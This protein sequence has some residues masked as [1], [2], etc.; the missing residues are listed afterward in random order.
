MNLNKLR[1]LRNCVTPAWVTR[2]SWSPGKCPGVFYPVL[3]LVMGMSS[4]AYSQQIVDEWSTSHGALNAVPDDPA[5]TL[6]DESVATEVVNGAGIITAVTDSDGLGER[7]VRVEFISGGSGGQTTSS[8]G[9]GNL[10]HGEVDSRGNTFI[11]WDGED[12]SAA[13]ATF[14]GSNNVSGGGLDTTGLRGTGSSGLNLEQACPGAQDSFALIAGDSDNSLDYDVVIDIFT[15][16]DSWSSLS[17][18]EID[19]GL[20]S[21]LTF[22]F[23]DFVAQGSDAN[24]ADFT[25]VGA[26]RM[27]ITPA[28]Q[29]V[30]LKV[31]TPFF[32]CGIDLGDAAAELEVTIPDVDTFTDFVDSR[33]SPANGPAGNSGVIENA[34]HAI[35]GPRLGPSVDAESQTAPP[36]VA[37]V[38][39]AAQASRDDNTGINDNDG[40]TFPS[41]LDLNAGDAFPV[42]ISV[43]N[44]LDSDGALLCGWIDFTDTDQLSDFGF[45]NDDNAVVQSDGFRGERL[46]TEVNTTNCAGTEPD[47]TCTLDFVIPGNWNGDNGDPGGTDDAF[48]SRFRVTTDWA[49]EAE[50]T[51]GGFASDGEVE[52][53]LISSST[54]PVSIHSFESKYDSEG[55]VLEWGTVSETRNVG[56]F[57]WGDLGNGL[58][59]LTPEMIPAKAVD[60]VRPHRYQVTVPGVFEGQVGDL[61][62]TAVDYDGDEEVYGLFQAGQAYGKKF[63]PAPVA[64][65]RIGANVRAR[66]SEHAAAAARGLKD[67]KRQGSKLVAYARDAG[68]EDSVAAVDVRT[69]AVGLHEVSWSDLADA[70]LDLAGVDSAEIAVTLKGQPV[71]RDITF[72]VASQRGQARHSASLGASVDQSRGPTTFGPGDVIRF[73]TVEP[74]LPDALYLDNYSY[75]ISVNPELAHSAG[76]ETTKPKSGPATHLE[77]IE[78]DIDNQY[79]FANPLEDPWFAARLRA[80]TNNVYETQFMVDDALRIDQPGTLE[81]VAGGFT[82]FPESP[83]HQLQVELN[84]EV[85]ADVRF[86]GLVEKRIVADVPAGL[87]RPG[88]N[89]VQVI[90]PG[91]TDAAF[92]VSIVDKVTLR[93]PRALVARQDRFLARN[94]APEGGL[95]VSGFLTTDTVAYA[96]D[97]RDLTRLA[98]EQFSRGT[99]RVPTLDSTNAD[100]WIS[101]AG[102][103]HA[104]QD[105][106]PVL[107][108][109]LLAGV[110]G[111]FVIIAHRAFL[112]LSPDEPHPL[113]DYLAA[114]QDEGWTP[115]VFDVQ[116]IQRQFGYGMTLPEAVTNFLR[117]ASAR[118]AFDHVLLVG[119]DSYDYSDN[120][121]LGSIS[122]I[123]TRY[124][125][126]RAIPHTPSDNLLGDI[127]G[128]GVSDKALGRWPVRSMGDLSAIVD[129]TLD[130]SGDPA[131][132]A[133]AAWV[134]DSQDPNQP[135]F[136]AQVQRMVDPLLNAGWMEN[137]IQQILLDEVEPPPGTSV[138]DAA[139][140]TYFDRLESSRSLS[141]FVGHGAP[142]MWT[143]QGLLTP[144]DLADLYN[145]GAPTLIGTL[146]CYTSYFV[147]PFNDTVA[148]RWMNG[149][150]EDA[151]GNRIDGV[152]NGAVAIHGAAT[153]SNYDQNGWFAREVLNKQ[154]AGQ[155][156]GQAILK[157]RHESAPTSDQVINWNLLGDPTLTLD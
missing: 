38:N 17:K 90:A 136:A 41:L 154:L 20:T 146:T 82:D 27:R 51:L 4:L 128:D 65:N 73:W 153:L 91:G 135:S 72:N 149:Y 84:G 66:L 152:P 106:S 111:D 68:R 75:R 57:V 31:L 76:I 125:P 148:H 103:V 88:A 96:W 56:F 36:N 145:E 89:T 127:D 47:L 2:K 79:H 100:Y 7:D 42:E 115:A 69:D 114:K 101:A 62:V 55:L 80:D 14:D 46:C 157:V 122:F 137:S 130:W 112:P 64:W 123:P 107:G 144:D 13:A 6:V 12:G 35:F 53:Y 48:L 87:L 81:V 147:S 132:I 30:D 1:L 39:G 118:F 120:L 5:T 113:N 9:S 59:L 52:D 85:L 97:G 74:T 109:D 119:S 129:K 95:T 104:P 63:D 23:D 3:L 133:N 67:Q 108:N 49:D 134:A 10:D 21:I 121:G 45:Q 86:N 32:T 110:S 141:G 150:R 98:R 33:V 28:G 102:A 37:G 77:V 94:A 15:D 34:H 29:D 117:E 11:I 116:Q 143:F 60:P 126:T 70:G 142:S 50:A 43:Q 83:D 124:A 22:P 71:A 58:E 18:T 92:D 40:V 151:Q 26:I 138:V 93:Y 54:L 105:L 140:R 25:N 78:Q 24:G 139:R 44:V 99:V 19:D 156:L 16:D 155:T 61:A 131:A 8:A